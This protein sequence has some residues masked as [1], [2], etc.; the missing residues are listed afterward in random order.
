MIEA[1]IKR[2]E[3]SVSHL[4]AAIQGLTAILTSS[5]SPASP[6]EA[7][8]RIAAI[9]RHHPAAPQSVCHDAHCGAINSDAVTCRHTLE[10]YKSEY[11]CG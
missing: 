8:G 11:H 6:P 7:I 9:E 4:T 1:E 5:E 3:K 2:L 10:R